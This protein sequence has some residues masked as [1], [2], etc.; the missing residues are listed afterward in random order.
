MCREVVSLRIAGFLHACRGLRQV[1]LGVT[2]LDIRS[3][4]EP[5][6]PWSSEW[7]S[8]ATGVDDSN[9]GATVERWLA[10]N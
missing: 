6:G 2:T 5:V 1:E 9:A 10:S 3:E 7:H 8:H 4:Q